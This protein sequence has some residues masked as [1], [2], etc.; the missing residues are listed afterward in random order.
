MRSRLL[1]MFGNAF[2][3]AS[4]FLIIY[5]I[6]PYLATIMP[7]ELTGLV[8]SGGALITLGL[9]PFVPPLVR[10]FGAR[11]LALA[12]GA[13]QLVFLLGNV[14][15]PP[16]LGAILFIALACGFSPIVAYLVDLMLEATI[17]DERETGRIRAAFLT[18]VNIALVISPLIVGWLLGT[19]T[20]YGRVFF[21][22]SLALVP[23]LLAL[24]VLRTPAVEQPSLREF[25]DVCHCVLADRDLRA[26][27]FANF[28]LQFFF[29]LAPFYTTLYLH[30]TLGIPWSQLGWIFALMLVPFILLEYP[31]GWFADKK[32][33]DKELMATGFTVLGVSFAAIAFIGV[34]TSLGT[35]VFVLVMTRVGAALVEAMA[36]GH[37]FRR[38]SSSDLT[39]VELFRTARPIAALIAPLIG[40]AILAV[41][42]YQTFFFTTGLIILIAGVWSA[43]LIRDVR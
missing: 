30:T 6:A 20:E 5:M 28:V 21:A 7:E 37:F 33:G 23:F 4:Y 35:I 43:F 14:F 18:A 24:H 22:A 11:K 10:R 34:G 15:G 3:A 32:L 26:V 29:H 25:W 16:A 39:T 12:L 40:T 13:L 8:I 19:T 38:V 2:G 1:L 36:D 17:A 41:S 42:N 9:F 27:T 31:A